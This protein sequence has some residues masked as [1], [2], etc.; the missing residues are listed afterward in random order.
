VGL[1][2]DVQTLL[3]EGGHSFHVFEYRKID[4]LQL[5]QVPMEF[6]EVASMGMELL[7]SP[8]LEERGGG[9]YTPAEAARARV[10]HLETCLLFWPYMAVV[11]AFQ[12]WAYQNPQEAAVPAGCDAAWTRLWQRFMPGVDWSGLDDE[13][14]TGWQRKLHIFTVPLYYVEYGLAL[15]GAVQVW[16]NAQTDP[17]G[18]VARYRQALALGGSVPLPEL[19]Q[20]AGAR[21][22]FDRDA[23]AQAVGLMENTIAELSEQN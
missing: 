15:L 11:D 7:A 22:A 20:T 21:L 13:L 19:Y 18:A 8:Y 9:F 3:H 2:D 10:Q 4:L 5:L 6:A 1:H 16:R 17:A 14:A 12:H 23:L